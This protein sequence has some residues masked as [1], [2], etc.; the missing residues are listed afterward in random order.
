MMIYLCV[1][2]LSELQTPYMVSNLQHPEIEKQQS[3][4][5]LTLQSPPHLTLQA[6]L[7]AYQSKYTLVQYLYTLFYIGFSALLRT[8]DI[9]GLL[10]S[11]CVNFL[12]GDKVM[13]FLLLGDF[14]FPPIEMAL[15]RENLLES[16]MD[17]WAL[18]W[19]DLRMFLQAH[20]EEL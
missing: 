5:G 7:C 20:L 13:A 14:L 18:C 19:L 15:D 6:D 16:Y 8:I 12:C 1:T 3:F 9:H 10:Y 17:H 4:R 2:L 11:K